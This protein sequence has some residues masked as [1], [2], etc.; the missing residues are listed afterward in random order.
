MD[1]WMDGSTIGRMNR[2]R[3]GG[4]QTFLELPIFYHHLYCNL[5]PLATFRVDLPT[6]LTAS[7]PT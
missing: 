6:G 2:R 5:E 1:G 7:Q 4:T 3:E